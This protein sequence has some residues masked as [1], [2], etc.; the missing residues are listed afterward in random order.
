MTNT[1]PTWAQMTDL[2]KGAALLHLHKREWEGADYAIENYPAEYF[3]HTV[4]AAL[5]PGQACDHAASVES[6]AVAL[7]ADEN[8]RLYDLAL[9][10]DDKRRDERASA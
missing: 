5:S 8:E 7:S 9:D 2:D 6:D 10:A 1:L 3:D 4:L